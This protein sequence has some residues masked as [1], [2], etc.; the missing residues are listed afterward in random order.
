M[1]VKAV[2]NKP[3]DLEVT[4]TITCQLS[5][6]IELAEQLSNAYPSWQLTSAINDV[7]YKA[8]DVFVAEK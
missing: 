6:W 5:E 7:V 8:K 1:Q 4:L 2:I 3:E